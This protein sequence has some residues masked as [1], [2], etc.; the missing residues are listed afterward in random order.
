MKKPNKNAYFGFLCL[1]FDSA[2]SMAQNPLFMRVSGFVGISPPQVQI[3]R[4]NTHKKQSI[5]EYNNMRMDTNNMKIPTW[6]LM[7]YA[8]KCRKYACLL[9]F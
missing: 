9:E 3:P 1:W 7:R 5:Q 6:L 2:A 8:R 4:K